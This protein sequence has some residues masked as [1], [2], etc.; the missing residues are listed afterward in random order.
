MCNKTLSTTFLS[1]I[2]LMRQ[3]TRHLYGINAHIPEQGSLGMRL[4][5][6]VSSATLDTLKPIPASVMQ[7]L[8]LCEPVL[9]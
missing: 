6:L 5:I 7:C 8:L 1:L 9:I 3:N 2:F 4:Y